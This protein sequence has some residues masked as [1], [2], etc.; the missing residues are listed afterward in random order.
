MRM[1]SQA[2]ADPSTALLKPGPSYVA[3]FPEADRRAAC[4][5]LDYREGTRAFADCMMGDFPEN[6]YF[7][8]AGN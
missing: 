1:A 4:E 5:R 8:Q 3:S 7:E 6:P 2:S